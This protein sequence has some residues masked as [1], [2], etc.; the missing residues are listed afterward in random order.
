MKEID[1]DLI[2]LGK[3]GEFD[4][5]GHGC[6]C[7]CRMGR[8]IAPQMDKAFGCNNPNLFSLEDDK[9][10]GDITKL[11]KIEYI[12][13]NDKLYVTNMYSQYHYGNPGVDGIPLDYS[14]LRRCLKRMNREFAG[15]HIGLPEI[16]CGLAGGD[17]NIVKQ[18][19]VEELIDC[20]VTLVHYKK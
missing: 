16:G 8:G 15:K 9:Y 4:V 6:N 17:I 5:I 3:Q 13:W 12:H 10:K 14:A 7:F 20:E 19:I 11:G 18:M 1:G 2:V